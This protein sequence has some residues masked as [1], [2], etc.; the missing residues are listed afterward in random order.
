MSLPNVEQTYNQLL[1]NPGE[2]LISQ[3]EA[4][5][6]WQMFQPDDNSVGIGAFGN[7]KYKAFM[8]AALAS[9]VEGSVA[10]GWVET[11]WR[12]SVKPNATVK[13]L[14]KKLAKHATKEFWRKAS[15]GEVDLYNNVLSMIRYQCAHYFRSIKQGLEI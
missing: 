9:A 8:Q 10:M 2:V 5:H 4:Y 1:K 7:F 14:L 13:G 15:G 12:G 3:T 11:I 6:V